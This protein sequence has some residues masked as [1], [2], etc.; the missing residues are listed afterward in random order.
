M[1]NVYRNRQIIKYAFEYYIKRPNADSKDIEVESNL[2]EK[3]KCIEKF[4]CI[5][6][7]K[8]FNFKDISKSMKFDP[9]KYV[10]P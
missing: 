3:N 9:S 1:F 5:Y 6:D 4:E 8:Y 10:V 7:I 2:L